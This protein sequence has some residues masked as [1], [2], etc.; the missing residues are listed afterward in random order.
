[1][2]PVSIAFF[3]NKGGV[4]K[5]SLVYH[6]AWK[7]ADEGLRV[8][9]ADLDPQA[10]L[11]AA[12]LDEDR[13]EELWSDEADRGTVFQAVQPL[14]RGTG[15][16]QPAHVEIVDDALAL[17]VGDFS[18]SQFEDELASQW[19]GCLGGKERSFRVI[20]SFWRVIE[21]AAEEHGASVILVDLGPHLGAINRAALIAADHV[22]V[23]VSPD[24]FSLQ[25]LRNLGPTLHRWREEWQDRLRKN[26][27]PEELELPSGAMQPAG[28]IVLQHAVRLDRPVKAYD[29]WIRRIPGTY[30]KYV[31]WQPL[32][33][34][35]TVTEDPHC[36]ALLK[37]YRSLMPMAQEARKP[38]F[39]LKAADGAIG[40]HSSSV[41]RADQ[42][43]LELAE[44]L[45]QAV[46]VP[47]PVL[48]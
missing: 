10:N 24:L 48:P 8:L 23:P 14:M 15:D 41:Q 35:M 42:D 29:K 31:L 46:G 40:A 2:T 37:H 44:H 34:P 39:H 3:N 32:E 27:R 33:E 12:F 7:L 21:K 18:L 28:Y 1:M 11:S 4:G 17:L 13:L 38:I 19:S 26:P 25:G 30:A 16:I 5:T 43:F 6:L 36:L 20:S 22:A 47:M 45:M 9:A